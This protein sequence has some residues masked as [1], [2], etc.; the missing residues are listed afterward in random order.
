MRLL[1]LMML[2]ERRW[3]PGLSIVDD[4]GKQAQHRP[5][6]KE[7]GR[8]GAKSAEEVLPRAARESTVG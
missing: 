3:P 6:A 1:G 2:P 8:K 5:A 7:P 4:E